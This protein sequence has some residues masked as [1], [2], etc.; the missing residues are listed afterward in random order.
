[1]SAPTFAKYHDATVGPPGKVSSAELT[2]C[3]TTLYHC[4]STAILRKSLSFFEIELA[5]HDDDDIMRIQ[6]VFIRVFW[7]QAHVFVGFSAKAAGKR[8]E[9]FWQPSKMGY[10]ERE[11]V[12]AEDG[13]VVKS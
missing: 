7:R 2:F 12:Q 10:D 9:S 3:S 8:A 11:G 5:P 1:M 4:L 6:L 13:R